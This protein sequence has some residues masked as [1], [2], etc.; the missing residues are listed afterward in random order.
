MRRSG[1]I[2]LPFGLWMAFLVLPGLL[3]AQKPEQLPYPS[4]KWH[5]AYTGKV[6]IRTEWFTSAR[7][8]RDGSMK[9]YTEALSDYNRT[10]NERSAAENRVPAQW[11][12]LG[13]ST[14]VHP[15]SAFQGL[16]SALWIDTTDFQTLY[17]G[18]NTGG[19]FR[20]TD[21]GENWHPL[22]HNTFTT[23]VL[24]IHVD[25][26]NKNRIIIGTGHYGFNRSYGMGVMISND[27]GESWEQTSLNSQAI[28]NSF[29]VQKTGMHPLSP[30]TLLALINTEFRIK[31]Y[32][33]RT[34]DGTDT[35]Q[36]VF[37]RPGLELFSL[38]YKPGEPNTVYACG[39]LL[40]KSTDAGETWEDRTPTLPLD[41]NFVL[42]RI[43]L[44]VSDRTPGLM[45]AFCESYDTTGTA[46]GSRR[47]MIRSFDEGE[48]WEI[49]KMK[50]DPLA[51]YWKMQL[52]LSPADNE[53][54]YL[55]GVWLF[56]YRIEGDSAKY[57]DCSDHKYHWD[58]RDLHVYPQ[59]GKDLMY[60]GNDGGVS[61]SYTG[62]ESWLDITR[63]GLQILQLHNITIGEN[64]NM[65]YGG[66]QD[67]NFAFYN[68]KTGGWSRNPRIS[69]AYDGAINHK[70]PNIVYMVGVPPKVNQPHLF[71]KKS[72]DGGLTF[73]LT[74][75][76]T[77]STEVGRWDKP[78]EMDPVDPDILYVG[79]RN[80]WKSVN[81]GETF[82][83]ISNFPP[84]G[85]PKLITIRIA[86]SNTSVIYA[87]F[88]NPDWGEPGKP[89]LFVTPDGGSRWL[90]I[91]PKGQLNL[92]YAGISDVAIHPEN[93]QKIWLSLD[94]MWS[95]HHVYFSEDAGRS[96]SNFSEGLPKLPVNT[97]KYVK[98]AGYDILLAA[99]DAG[100]YYRDETLNKWE[101]FGEGL[102]QTIVADLAISYSRKKIVA[103]TFGR[104][105][106]ETDLCLPVTEGEM[107]IENNEVWQANRK[108]LQNV[109]VAPGAKLTINSNIEVGR[110]RSVSVMPG[111]KLSIEG[112]SLSND[113][114][115]L[116]EGIKLYGSND[117]TVPQAP[118]GVVEICFGGSIRNAITAI[119]TF[120]INDQGEVEENTGGGIIYAANALFVNNRRSIVI[121][122]AKG[123]NP[124]QFRLSRFTSGALL[125]DGSAP[126][127][128]VVIEGNS[129]ITFSSC[130]FENTIPATV[131]PVWKHGTGIRCLNASVRVNRLSNDSIPFGLNAEPVFRQLAAG[132][133]SVNT[134]PG[135]TLSISKVKFDRNLT[136]LYASGTGLFSLTG[137]N[138]TVG[139]VVTPDSVKR[140]GS[141]LYLDHCS[142]FRI[143]GNTFTG[144]LSNIMTASKS[145]GIVIHESGAHNNLIMGNAIKNLNFGLLV[146][147][148]N[149][150]D[151]GSRGLRIFRNYFND[152]EYDLCATHDTLSR[153]NGIA[154]HQGAK[155]S[156]GAEPADNTF[157]YSR[158]HR[159]GDIH[160]EGK[161]IYYHYS[162]LP[163]EL[164]RQPR[165][166][167][168]GI[169][170]V[171][172]AGAAITDSSYLP[173][174]IT[175]AGENAADAL[176]SWSKKAA[177]EEKRYEELLDGGNS[178][179]LIDEIRY[180]SG[181]D[182]P[183]L[184][185]GL[186]GLSP[187]LSDDAL[188]ALIGN[189]NFPNNLLTE[190]LQ[191]NPHF[192][193][194]PGVFG[195][196]SNRRP[197]IQPFLLTPLAG[198][199][200]NY[201]GLELLRSSKDYFRAARDEIFIRIATDIIDKAHP[202]SVDNSLAQFLLTD[203]R[204]VSHLTAAGLAQ[205]S[206]NPDVAAAIFGQI[207]DNFP[208]S[209]QQMQEWE[210]L[211]RLNNLRFAAGAAATRPN[212]TDSLAIVQLLNGP[213]AMMALNML[214][215]FGL[216]AYTEPYILPGN[217][218]ADTIPAM[219]P[220]IVE[221]SGMR[222]FPVPAGDF[223][224]VE[225]F[226][227]HTSGS[228]KIIIYS[229]TGSRVREIAL[230]ETFGQILINTADLRA[231]LYL[232]NLV[233]NNKTVAR[234]K[235]IIYR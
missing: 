175:E 223:A 145:A 170:A 148:C 219:P 32:I 190:I 12:P 166:A 105:L 164:K 134:L 156:D 216:T 157:S 50:A 123:I 16:V 119:E 51:G 125:P 227:D 234:Q 49:L 7:A 165:L 17:A 84:E 159:N 226:S 65:M 144:Q 195:L 133:T 21:G 199:Y 33:Y 102:P 130:Q 96:W 89:K 213:A 207:G 191:M 179:A 188:K 136:G 167:S 61:V 162:P 79:V 34:T 106:W 55:G 24:S 183:A 92:N 210:E 185:A 212:E 184:Y 194:I 59:A 6:F 43:A 110:G 147:N 38:N 201:S 182:A 109:V 112:G 22:S 80:V 36:E 126:G 19:I 8:G 174:F 56:K 81:G 77:D 155:G 62:A 4:G 3:L 11:V 64:S 220:V 196:L 45:I 206:G 138:F 187:Y 197:E 44:S 225:Y 231:G 169:L 104:G 14:T 208:G 47:F 152:N 200:G 1:K 189:G 83:R 198:A 113:C 205:K 15:V 73:P 215:R 71:L 135:H 186:K 228:H 25:P 63:N 93:P 137:S 120:G 140:I 121:K 235:V 31:G 143:S 192:I 75:G 87:A 99:T 85:D 5:P 149:R 94:R 124:S 90:D 35:W 177:N 180:H 158:W 40:L 202:E 53:E 69:D 48:T 78:L 39:N 107:V 100:V 23:G 222:V 68:F 161:T 131:I 27:G 154:L 141:G 150:N 128:M 153:Q 178:A 18:S 86:P 76:I 142:L 129:G 88:E 171:E 20:T 172:N 173:R 60:M 10:Q 209:D 37:S 214:R 98:G 168:Y 30:D 204:P 232:F 72:T 116:W 117:Y 160:N 28:P 146:Q 9:D 67:G 127:D 181:Y 163:K 2:L 193:R 122:P 151:D 114:F 13:P 26:R 54:F 95:N 221:G 70:D 82:E 97:I 58:I 233:M 29:V 132:I 66:P 46:G 115:E 91:T 224:V 211:F 230:A 203:D 74:L 218:V 41:T 52:V 139:S 229:S 101:P 217:P 118:Q 57:I 103:G 42:S 176:E 111:G 108:M